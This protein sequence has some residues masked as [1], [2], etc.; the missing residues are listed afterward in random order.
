MKPVL[1][2]H[3]ADP[4]FTKLPLEDYVLTFDDGLYSQYVFYNEIKHVNTP[5][6]FFI[7]SGIICADNQSTEFITCRDAHQK[8]FQGN[9]ENYMTVEQIQYMLEDPLVSIG[10]HSHSHTRLDTFGTLSEKVA[11][12]KSDAEKT[13]QW[14][15]QNLGFA[16]TKFCFPYNEDLDGLYKGLLTKYGF[17]EF[18]GSG[19][20]PVETLLRF[21]D[22]LG[23]LDTLPA[24]SLP[25]YS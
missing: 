18:Y 10:A 7:S 6:I 21:S 11:Y 17:T 19:R 4:K 22:Q 3:E 16:P 23:N 13:V 8:A 25:R 20:T 9:Y 2:I 1:M 24:W 14:F 12:I 5:K 15:E